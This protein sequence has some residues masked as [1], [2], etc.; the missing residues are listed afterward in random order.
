MTTMSTKS[1]NNFGIDK[2]YHFLV[3]GIIAVIILFI[4]KGSD[5]GVII[6]FFGSLGAGIFKEYIIDLK[7]RRTVIEIDDIT[8]TWLG[9]II[10]IMIFRTIAYYI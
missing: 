7:I 8:F 10:G 6:A 5:L 9:G 1:P 2:L 3:G 4:F